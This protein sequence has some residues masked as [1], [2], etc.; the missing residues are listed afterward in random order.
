MITIII[1]FYN[2]F[3]QLYNT[4]LSVKN[5]SLQDWECLLVDDGSDK[6]ELFRINE[7]ILDDK[8][9]R[10]IKRPDDRLKGANA[11]RNI[12][13]EN[14]KGEY[15]ALLDSDDLW[16][17]NYLTDYLKFVKSVPEFSGAFAKCLI[18]NGEKEWISD[19]RNLLENES[20]FDFLLDDKAIAQ[21]STFFMKTSKAKDVKFDESLLR[22]QDW[23]FFIR[24]GE[25]FNWQ[26][27]PEQ[28]VIV[29]WEKGTKR[30]IHFPSCIKVYNN[31]KTQISN[32]DNSNRYLFSMYEK[33]LQYN[34]DREIK[35][36]YLEQLKINNYKVKT[37]RE[38]LMV[39]YPLVYQ[40]LRNFV[41]K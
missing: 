40:F 19:S 36:F 22:H 29:I 18:R 38:L 7:S 11:C 34:V 41:K 21:T 33:A 1:P 9:F 27:N 23:D 26:Y 15:V 37:K 31:F 32:L 6:E 28:Y 3:S 2:R 10:I 16:P 14:A 5:Q 30:T 4:L 8:R 24:F 17:E 35:D 20:G 13:I 25:R 12:G 39:K